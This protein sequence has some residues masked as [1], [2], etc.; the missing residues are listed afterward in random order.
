MLCEWENTHEKPTRAY[1]CNRAKHHT[2]VYTTFAVTLPKA[3]QNFVATAQFPPFRTHTVVKFI[4]FQMGLDG[5]VCTVIPRFRFVSMY[6]L[7]YLW[8]FTAPP[9]K[10][11][12][13]A[14]STILCPAAEFWPK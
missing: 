9:T 10:S 3:I 6:V 1:T 5:G 11:T 12:R 13:C 7:V 2:A 8:K 14:Q 4:L